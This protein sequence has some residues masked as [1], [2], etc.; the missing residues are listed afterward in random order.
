MTFKCWSNRLFQVMLCNCCIVIK[1]S[2]LNREMLFNAINFITR[3][4]CYI[5][6]KKHI[7]S[8]YYPLLLFEFP[9]AVMFL[10]PPRPSLYFIYPDSWLHISQHIN[11][12]IESETFNCIWMNLSFP[13]LMKEFR[14]CLQCVLNHNLI[15]RYF[16]DQ[17]MYFANIICFL[18]FSCR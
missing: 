18:C 6:L 14:R 15:P 1:I 16:S 13:D 11:V 9:H 2:G 10:N 5:W 3:N 8:W 12:S 7:L 17:V 4:N